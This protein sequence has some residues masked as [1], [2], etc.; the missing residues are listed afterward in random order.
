M[1]EL[2]VEWAEKLEELAKM[3]RWEEWSET[4]RIEILSERCDALL[5]RLN[6]QEQLIINLMR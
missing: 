3:S 2:N 4:M 5:R 1:N 6:E